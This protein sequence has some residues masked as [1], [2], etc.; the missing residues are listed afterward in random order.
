M[1]Q[2]FIYSSL[3]DFKDYYM[4][5]FSK[6]TGLFNFVFTEFFISKN[7]LLDNKIFLSYNLS[8]IKFAGCNYNSFINLN[9]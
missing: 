6:F 3:I 4:N 8:I 1:S 2:I 7:T 5:L 9:Y